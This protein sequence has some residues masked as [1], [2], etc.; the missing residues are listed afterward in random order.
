MEG[1]SL[2]DRVMERRLVIKHQTPFEERLAGHARRLKDKAKKLP[3]GSEQ[4]ELI[5]KARQTETASHLTEWLIPTARNC[6][7]LGLPKSVKL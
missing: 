7:S 1:K 2:E 5:R 4:D 3:P 6:D